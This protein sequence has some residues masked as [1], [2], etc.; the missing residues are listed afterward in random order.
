AGDFELTGAPLRPEG[1]K[2]RFE[3]GFGNLSEES[4]TG[5]MPDFS[6]AEPLASAGSLTELK[7]LGQV[8]SSFIVAINDEGLWIVDQHVA[9]ER[10][11][12]EK[13]LRARREG[14]M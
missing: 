2:F 14:Q 5:A 13:H 10:V 4:F 12:F 7:P 8:N 3:G 9:H 11:L 6:G 1:Q